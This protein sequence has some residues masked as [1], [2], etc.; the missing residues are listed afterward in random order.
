MESAVPEATGIPERSELLNFM[1]TR[2]CSGLEELMNH[3]ANEE[4]GDGKD[5]D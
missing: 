3:L 1:E 5:T 4:N 2:H